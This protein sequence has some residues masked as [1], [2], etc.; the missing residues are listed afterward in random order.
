M[1]I[2]FDND[3]W[4][5]VVTPR[6]ILKKAMEKISVKCYHCNGVGS[7]HLEESYFGSVDDCVCQWCYG[8]GLLKRDLP[9]K[10]PPPKIDEKFLKALQN[11]INDYK[12]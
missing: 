6:Y 12:D 1:S 10:N 2:I 8:S 5:L 11:F 3:E 4:K 9:P 7:I